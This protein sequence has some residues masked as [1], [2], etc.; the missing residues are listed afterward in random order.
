M[1]DA[2]FEVQYYNLILA[3]DCETNAFGTPNV[4][5]HALLMKSVKDA[6]TCRE[7]VLDCFET[8]SLPILSERQT[9]DALHVVMVGGGPTGVKLAAVLFELVQEHLLVIYPH[10]KGIVA[11]SV[12]DVAD[13]VLG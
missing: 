1:E 12:H 5:E 11:I 9:K 6:Q 3:P 4:K 8:A 10:F 2:E 13:R 7:R